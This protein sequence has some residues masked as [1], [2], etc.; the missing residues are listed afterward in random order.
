[1]V[2]LAGPRDI[3]EQFERRNANVDLLKL[4]I[5]NHGKTTKKGFSTTELSLS[6]YGFIKATADV[7]HSEVAPFKSL[8]NNNLR[9]FLCPKFWI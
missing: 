3:N 7:D 5:E 4:L 1:M 2:I 8:K 6:I 9:D